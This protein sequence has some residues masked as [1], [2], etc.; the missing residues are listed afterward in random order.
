MLINKAHCKAY[1]LE[2]SNTTRAGKFKRVSADVW[3]YLESALIEKMNEFVKYHPSIGKTLMV[4]SKKRK[5]VVA[6]TDDGLVQ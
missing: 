5:K 4:E 3:P 2:R 6:P 1:L